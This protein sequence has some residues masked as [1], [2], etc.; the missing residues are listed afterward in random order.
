MSTLRIGLK[1]D[2]TAFRPGEGIEGAVGWELSK[3]VDAIE[4]RLFWHT[5]G[6][7]SEDVEIVDRVRFDRPSQAEARPFRFA[8][9]EQPYSFSGKLI[10]VMWAVEIV[11]LPGEESSRK[12]I[13]IAPEAQEIVLEGLPKSG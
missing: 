13:I 3:T 11:V 8:A 7:G 12:D 5:R 4:V 2:R 6:K 10:S 1:D 9:P